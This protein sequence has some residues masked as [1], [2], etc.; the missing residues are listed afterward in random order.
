MRETGAESQ[1]GPRGRAG[2]CKGVTTTKEATG[3]T[4]GAHDRREA[5]EVTKVL[6]AT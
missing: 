4:R 6:K 2:P 3:E 5:Q 1:A